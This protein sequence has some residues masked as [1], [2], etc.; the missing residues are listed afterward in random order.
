MM[1]GRL[2][3]TM[4]LANDEH[5]ERRIAQIVGKLCGTY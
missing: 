3:A 1:L 5:I 4:E 2:T